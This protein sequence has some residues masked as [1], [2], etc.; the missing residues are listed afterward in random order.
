ML[1]GKK[2]RFY[3]D[4]IDSVTWYTFAY[5]LFVIWCS[6]KTKSKGL[7]LCRPRMDLGMWS[8]HGVLI[9]YIELVAYESNTTEPHLSLWP[10]EYL[11]VGSL[12]YH[13]DSIKVKALAWHPA[14]LDL[15]PQHYIWVFK[16]HL[17]S[18]MSTE[19]QITPEHCQV[20]TFL[21]EQKC[22]QSAWK[23]SLTMLAPS[24]PSSSFYN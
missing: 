19:P 13:I 24:C 10:F 16:Y 12:G 1:L 17:G 22:W 20:S 6:V 15:N 5:C 2:N 8:N 23:W 4:W 9:S 3:N 11:E 14:N 18:L 21:K 7:I